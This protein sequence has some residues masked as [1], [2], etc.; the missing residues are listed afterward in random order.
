MKKIAVVLIA[1][2]SIW[3]CSKESANTMIVTGKVKGM[4]KGTLLLQ[5]YNDSLIVTVDSVNIDGTDEFLLSHEIE[6]P[7]IYY[8]VMENTDK[9][10][11]FFGDADSIY[12]NTQLDKFLLKAEIKGGTNQ[13][14]WDKYKD[15]QK[16]FNNKNLDLIK[17]QFE[18]QQSGSQDSIDAVEKKLK[19]WTKKKYLYTTNFA[20]Q[21][22]DHEI[23]P[24]LA[25][26]ELYNANITLLDTVNNVLSDEVKAS[27]YGKRL[28]AFIKEIKAAESK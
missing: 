6:S 3:A 5:K 12:V 22:K 14:L 25:L 4:K 2:L 18:A 15:V 1:V 8:L 27:K 28:D 21:N 23:A 17:E 7:E 26:T 24:Y 10:V 20:V 19:N 9:Q 13:T 16:K 11:S